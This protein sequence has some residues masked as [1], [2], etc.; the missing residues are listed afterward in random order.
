MHIPKY[1]RDSP[2]RAIYENWNSFRVESVLLGLRKNYK[3][4]AQIHAWDPNEITDLYVFENTRIPWPFHKK[5]DGFGQ[6]GER[7]II[8]GLGFDIRQS[9]GSDGLWPMTNPIYTVGLDERGFYGR[10]RNLEAIFIGETQAMRGFRD[11]R[12]RVNEHI[13]H[14]KGGRKSLLNWI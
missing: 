5:P 6:I 12:L 3:F 8:K 14:E 2:Y 10:Y 9:G 4:V 7:H 11:L 13:E 1:E